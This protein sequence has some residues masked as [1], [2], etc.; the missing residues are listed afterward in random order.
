[1]T[2]ITNKLKTF[3][4]EVANIT[5][6][7]G[8]VYGHPSTDFARAALIKQAVSDCPH[9]LVRHALEMIGVKMARLTETPDHLES[10]IDISGYART[11]AMILDR[12]AQPS[13]PKGTD[14]TPGDFDALARTIYGEARGESGRLPL[15]AVGWVVRNR[16]DAD[17]WRDNRP[18]WWGEGYFAVCHKPWQFSCWNKDD[19]NRA[20]I[21]AVD[22]R[23]IRLTDCLSAAMTV[24]TEDDSD[25]TNGCT[26][27]YRSGTREPDWAK[28]R[29][30]E[31]TIG[32]HIFFKD[33]EGV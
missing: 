5:E 8:S 28:G 33:I 6:R 30:V 14:M 32:N 10:V 21:K 31:V 27:Y 23:D 4:S 20:A 19:P 3:D 22:Y 2:A 9:H 25:P 7:R 18:D 17:L 24:L 13:N 15:M 29:D 16:V 12:D 11:I 26:H 1:M